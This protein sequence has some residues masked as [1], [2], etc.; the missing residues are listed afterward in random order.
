MYEKEWL[1]ETIKKLKNKMDVVS[2]RTQ[3]K[4]P[5][6]SEDGIHD[7]Y[8]FKITQWTNGFWGG[9]LWLMYM[10]TEDEHYKNLAIENE[11]KLDGAFLNF[12][13][14]SHDVGFLWMPTAGLHH[15]LEKNDDSYR[16]LFYAANLL[17][18]RFH[19]NGQFF[20]AWNGE[21]GYCSI[22]DCMMNIS[23]LYY[24]SEQTEDP[25]FRLLAMAHADTTMKQHIREDGS[26]AHIVT[27]DAETGEMLNQRAGQ[28]YADD[29]AWSRG[30]AWAVYGFAISYMYTGEKRYLDTAKKA[31][32]Y[33]LASCC[34]DFLPRCDFKAPAE[35]LVYDASAG[36]IAAC[37]MLDIAAHCG[38]FD[39]DKYRNGAL[40]L[41]QTLEAH[42]CDWSLDTDFILKNSSR[43]YGVMTPNGRN[44]PIIFGDYYFIEAL[45]HLYKSE[46]RFW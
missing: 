45:L 29:S 14:L 39:A 21:P 38:D 33:F 46:F 7:D 16:R 37:G 19:N 28:G 18:G 44:V 24:M 36:A 22:I 11:K 4:L 13:R 30:Q 15:K 32:N 20:R 25:R 34:D 12:E 6:T 27:H 8:S 10:L 1:E 41:L 9:M 42:F 31:A 17:A 23:L 43:R 2:R 40:K 26:V 3:L 5:F 35:P